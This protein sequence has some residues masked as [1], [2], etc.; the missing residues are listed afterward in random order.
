MHGNKLNGFEIGY[1][2]PG[3]DSLVF[4]PASAKI[5]GNKVI[6]WSEKVNHPAEVRYAWVLAGEANLFNKE[7]LPAFPFRR[8]IV[9]E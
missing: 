7:G 5:E 9:K 4:V 1:T 3:K 2:L 6:V 8:Q